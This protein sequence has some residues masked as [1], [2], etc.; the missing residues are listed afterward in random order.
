MTVVDLDEAR[1]RRAE[2]GLGGILQPKPICLLYSDC[3]GCGRR[4]GFHENCYWSRRGGLR[5]ADC[6]PYPLRL[7]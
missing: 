6:G 7:A 4:I 2:I 5:C 3:A 1:S